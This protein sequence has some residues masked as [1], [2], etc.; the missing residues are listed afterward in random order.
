[1]A[2]TANAAMLA[3]YEASKTGVLTASATIDVKK[4]FHT[5]A[6]TGTVAYALP[7]GRFKG[8]ILSVYCISVASTPHGVITPTVGVNCTSVDLILAK[9]WV[10]WRWDGTGWSVLGTGAHSNVA[11]PIIT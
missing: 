11:A 9:Q 2:R 1:M 4:R 7:A 3:A 5:A 8:Q 6:V 10:N